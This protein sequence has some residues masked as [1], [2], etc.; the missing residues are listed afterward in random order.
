MKKLMPRHRVVSDTRKVVYYYRP[1]PDGSR[2]IFGGR[3]TGGDSDLLKSGLLLRKEL[4]KVFP[5]IVEI[6]ITHSWMGF[7]AYTF[8]ELPHIGNNDGI[9]YAMGCCGSGVGMSSYLGSKL[10]HTILGLNEVRTGLDRIEF[11]TR[12]F[13]NG[14]PWFLPA[15]VSYYKWLDRIS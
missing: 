7:V 4:I 9:Y 14:N 12:P 15:S 6:K 11:K 2:I 13:Y 10:G 5:Q 3:V 8:D 1:S